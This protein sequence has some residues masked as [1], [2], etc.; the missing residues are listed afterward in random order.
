[1]LTSL[2]NHVLRWAWAIVA[3]ALALTVAA[4]VYGSGVFSHL[5][6]DDGFEGQ[7]TEAAAVTEA[8]HD[9]FPQTQPGAIVLFTSR[10]GQSVDTPATG[11][12]VARLLQPLQGDATLIATYYTTH[13]AALLANDKHQTYAAVN[14]KGTTD[15]Q[16]QR[17]ADFM[18]D[19]HS[20]TLDVAVG[21]QL[22]A[23]KQANNQVRHDLEVVELITLPLLAV[24]LVLV[25][26][27]VVAAAM[28]L[29]LGIVAIIGGLAVT[30]L[31]T[32]VTSIDQYA[33]NVITVLGLGLSVDYSLLMVSRFREEL[34]R[35]P[36][37]MSAVRRTLMT[38]GRTIFFSGLTVIISLL[39]L[40]LF[41]ID[42][43]RSISLGG[44]AALVVA[45]VAALTLLPAM[46]LVLGHRINAWRFGRRVDTG[47]GTTIWGRINTAAS[48]LPWVTIAAAVAIVLE[49]AVPFW[50]VAYSA[51]D[52]RSL[53]VGTSSRVVAEAL[54]KNFGTS[55]SNVTVLYR[56]DVPGAEAA[57]ALSRQIKAV[58][59]VTS[60][61]PAAPSKDGQAYKIVAHYTA[62]DGSSI[63]QDV[64]HDI[65]ALP[66]THGSVRVGGPAALVVD[67]VGVIA[68]YLPWA[69]LMI[70]VAMG[71]L[72]TLMLRSILIPLQAILLSAFSLLAAFGVLVLVFQDGWLADHTWFAQTGALS[73]TILLLIFT[74]SFGLSMDYAT[75]LYSRIREEYDRTG[76][77]P[78]AI[79]TGV[80]RTG[81][82][83]TAA[84]VLMFAVV[85]SF[86]SSR[87]P[88]LQQVGLGM[89]LAV[90]VD[91]FIVRILLVPSVMLLLGRANWW[92]P[93]AL[94]RWRIRHE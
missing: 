57:G 74:M 67:T 23:N 14:L 36:D 73:P 33:V 22:V 77:T 1:M 75:F 8:L 45:I 16:Y 4:G 55:D 9:E 38:S 48:K 46:L 64:V 37:V 71:L 66:D 3:V 81:Y 47:E 68:K 21:G 20:D 53:P 17:L 63:G 86:A 41:P 18:R 79:H 34:N 49:M 19:A 78:A 92:A 5:S 82:I 27:G 42:F 32:M 61:E 50:H 11:N 26:R 90:L 13:A 65:R 40:S 12:E 59:G 93:A 58:G 89:A 31:L 35:Q 54:A 76:D 44:I 51:F 83:I 25:F 2:T 56:P 84:A 28:P 30:R 60:V 39:S 6:S 91:A 80:E 10:D 15:E 7:G 94:S 29:M 88:S 62:P 24:L 69:A 70:V 72:L 43:L 52:Y 85:G 87:I